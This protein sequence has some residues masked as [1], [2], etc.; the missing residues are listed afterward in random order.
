MMP[1]GEKMDNDGN[2]AQRCTKMDI[3]PAANDGDRN[4]TESPLGGRPP[5]ELET[6]HAMGYG[7]DKRLARRIT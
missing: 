2:D 1:A 6:A 3:S 7:S 4:V 5:L